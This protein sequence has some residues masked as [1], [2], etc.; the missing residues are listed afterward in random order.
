MRVLIPSTPADQLGRLKAAA[1][2]LELVEYSDAADALKK[3]P[4]ADGYYGVPSPELI[5][6]GR[7]LQWIQVG[8]AGVE[9]Y[10]FPELINS[11]LTLTNAKVIYG[12]HLADHVLAFILAFN[13]NLPQLWRCQQQE[14]WEPRSKLRPMEMAGETLLIVGLGGTGHEV[15]K[16][17]AA[18]DMRIIATSRR[19]K[20]PTPGI[21]Y[22]GGAN[23][24]HALLPK[25]DHVALCCALTPETRNLMSDREFSLMK[26]TAYVH[27]VTRGGVIDQEALIRALRAGTIA[28]AG[29]DV[30]EPEP[31]PPGN[32]LWSMPNVLIT[33]HTSGH[34]PRA[35]DRMFELLAENLR[36]F[37]SGA[38]LLNVVD[39]Q[40]GS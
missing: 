7:N 9:G 35:G 18:F 1:P 29:L 20:P 3:I 5:R 19:P 38:P 10:R 27:N 21:E 22:I 30:T 17:A 31:L 12:A 24:L 14:V 26:K 28:G 33:A 6:A 34:S 32:P 11:K 16:R 37:A 40:V 23:E 8:S 36:R 25:A 4:E 2:T 13:R 39:K 15:A